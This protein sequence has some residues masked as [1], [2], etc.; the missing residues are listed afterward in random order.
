MAGVSGTAVAGTR[1]VVPPSGELRQTTVADLKPHLRE[2]DGYTELWTYHVYLDNDVQVYVNFTRA[3][4]GSFKGE[5]CGADLSIVGLGRKGFAVAKEY[6]AEKFKWIDEEKM[7]TVNEERELW[8]AGELPVEHRV[9]YKTHKK[10]MQYD[11]DIVFSA[12]EPGWVW[13]DGAFAFGADESVSILLHIPYA[14]VSASVLV[15]S[16]DGKIDESMEIVGT[17]YMD[18]TI[19]SSN[20]PKLVK[21][22]YRFM[23]HDSPM[24]V[25]YVVSPAKG[26]QNRPIGYGLEWTDE[27]VRLHKPNGL[28][29]VARGKV[30]KVEIAKTLEIEFDQKVVLTRVDDKQ[31]IS[32]FKDLGRMKRWA[33]KRF[34]GGETIMFRGEAKLGDEA[35]HYSFFVTK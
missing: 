21:A 30:E 20:A 27:G 35:A 2:K 16:D 33:A 29:V 26:Y 18:H 11:I 25:G 31:S 3:N 28:K 22:G 10:G 14:E 13:G 34:A 4:L 24:K 8:F 7:L 23:R 19:Y 15:K 1:R 32:L 17:A 9:R 5:V 6:P 12:I